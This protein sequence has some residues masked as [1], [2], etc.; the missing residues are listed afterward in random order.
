MPALATT[1]TRQRARLWTIA[2]A[3]LAVFAA[4]E[5]AFAQKRPVVSNRERQQAAQQ[6]PQILNEFGGEITGPVS[7]YV[8]GIGEKMA[9][10]AGVPNTCNFAV[11]NSDVANA[12]A[13]PGCYI[14]ISRGLLAIMNSED[15]LASVLGHEVGHITGRHSAGRQTRSVLTTLGAIAVGVATGNSELAQL[16]GQVGQLYTLSY[17]RGQEFDADDRGVAYLSGA[18]YNLF[19]ASDMLR[20]LGA[21]DALSARVANRSPSQIPTWARTHPLTNDRVTRAAGRAQAAGAT[22]TNP[23]ERTD[24]YLQT[25]SGMIFGD[26]PEQGFVNGRTF[27]HPKLR[28]A[29]E[30][31]EGFSL[32]NTSAAVIIGGPN[33]NRA[34]FA[35]GAMPPGGLEQYVSDG[36]RKVLGQARAEI[37]QPQRTV[38]NGLPTVFLPARAQNQQGQI[39]DLSLTAYD[40]GG[41]VYHFLTMAPANGA[42]AMNPMLRSMRALNDADVAALRPRIIQSVRVGAND[43]VQS[44]AQRMAFPNFQVERFTT[45]NAIDASQPLR[46]GQLVKIIVYG[47]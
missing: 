22:P 8:K 19:A 36:M 38:T 23:P 39:I 28:I 25:I 29:F 35:G 46:P 43:S 17:S 34:Q 27:A 7:T 13:V 1:Q 3:A 5:P 18:G 2:L 20:A 24:P 9:V 31:P 6:H 12:F 45:L 26:D 37:G 32:T 30:A 14:Y 41:R 44:L 15:E 10:A 33:N 11:I 47:R 42:A 16:A 21:N 40:V 4:A